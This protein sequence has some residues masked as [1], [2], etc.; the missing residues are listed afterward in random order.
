MG[1]SCISRKGGI[2]EKGGGGW[3]RKGGL[4]NLLPTMTSRW[5]LL[6]GLSL[7]KLEKL[8]SESEEHKEASL[9][10]QLESLIV[11]SW[12]LL[13]DIWILIITNLRTFPLA[14]N[15]CYFIFCTL[16]RQTILIK[17]LYFQI[18]RVVRELKE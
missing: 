2:L 10:N 15:I 12:S 11:V 13:K 14:I 6:Y 18:K 1:T 16:W 3:P 17:F 5:L 4:W 7:P 9:D 8:S